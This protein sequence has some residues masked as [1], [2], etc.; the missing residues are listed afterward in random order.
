MLYAKVRIFSFARKKSEEAKTKSKEKGLRTELKRY[1]SAP[2]DAQ[3][4]EIY[5][6]ID[7]IVHVGISSK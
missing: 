3:I 2:L 5:T 1:E 6:L 7:R 4:P